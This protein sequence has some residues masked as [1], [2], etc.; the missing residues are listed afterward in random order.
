MT[1]THLQELARL[2]GGESSIRSSAALSELPECP[3]VTVEG[4]G[5]L[6]LPLTAA[7]AKKLIAH[8]EPAPF[9]K[10]EET[11]LDTTVRHTW[12]FPTA[13][14]YFPMVLLFFAMSACWTATTD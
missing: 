3:T 9:G 10:G 1:T 5:E 7:M 8:G 4:Y 14:L 2:L 13:I 12:Y 11:L 6:R